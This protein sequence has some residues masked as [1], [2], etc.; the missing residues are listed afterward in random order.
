MVLVVCSYDATMS[1]RPVLNTSHFPSLQYPL[2]VD[3]EV[4]ASSPRLQ[5]ALNPLN[6]TS[7][8]WEGELS[9]RTK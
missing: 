7:M 4:E 3:A 9:W 2:Y 8:H 1:P 6:P 5:S